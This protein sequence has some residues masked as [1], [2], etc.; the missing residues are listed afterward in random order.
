MPDG[1]PILIS[2]KATEKFILKMSAIPGESSDMKG[3]YNGCRLCGPSTMTS[4]LDVGDHALYRGPGRCTEEK[5][6]K[7]SHFKV[8]SETIKTGWYRRQG[9]ILFSG[10]KMHTSN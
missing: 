9:L 4:D 1:A 8:V 6:T 3:F 7:L 10:G 2:S 5:S